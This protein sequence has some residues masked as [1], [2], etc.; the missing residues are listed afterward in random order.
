MKVTHVI[1]KGDVGGAQT[2]VVELA[3]A[4]KGVGFDVD[5]VAGCDGPAM[6][7]L[8]TAGVTVTIES[9]LGRSVALRADRLAVASLRRRF[10]ASKPDIVHAH[11][12]KGGLLARVAARWEGVPSVYTAHGFPFQRNA[13][14]LQRSM[15]VVGEWVGGHLGDA[16][17]CLTEDEA[18]LARRWR[19]A[20]PEGIHVVANALPDNAPVRTASRSEHAE[21]LMVS[22]F[23]PPK[24]QQ[25]LIEVLSTMLDLPWTISFVGDG[26]DFDAGRRLGASLLGERAR[27]L[28]HR[29]DVTELS[30]NSDVSILWSRYE[31]MPMAL[32]ESM[33]AGLCCVASDLPGVRELFGRPPAGLT[34]ASEAELATVLRSILRDPARRDQLGSAARTRFEDA[35]TM[36]RMSA[37][38]A[39][40]YRS[41]IDT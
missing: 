3:T 29:D 7:R 18:D 26:P 17:I 41:V 10:S 38:I 14:F 25:R 21:L 20:R 37:A 6:D 39:Q 24:Q 40:I 36:D 2:Y 15:S 22:R 1:T 28:G 27:F 34:A 23:A 8:R 13:P 19:I 11:S 4:Q 31:G 12:S 9:D 35:F 30:A 32:L 33:R 5:V 16:V